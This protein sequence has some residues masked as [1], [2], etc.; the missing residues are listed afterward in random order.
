MRNYL[1]MGAI[2]ALGLSGCSKT[3]PDIFEQACIDE[4][5]F[6][7]PED[8]TATQVL[9]AQC[10]CLATSAKD[11]LSEVTHLRFLEGVRTGP[12]VANPLV[13]GAEHAPNASPDHQRDIAKWYTQAII[14]D[15]D[16]H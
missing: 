4:Q 16:H 10:A 12:Q 6:G 3:Q 15:C 1:A 8:G 11:T 14:N 7:T 13:R 9:E 5:M 2:L